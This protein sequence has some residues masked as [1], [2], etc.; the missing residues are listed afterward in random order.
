MTPHQK[1]LKAAKRG[2]GLRLTAAEVA[3]LAADNA[4]ATCAENDDVIAPGNQQ[5][6]IRCGQ[7]AVFINPDTG[8]TASYHAGC[9]DCDKDG[10][11]CEKCYRSNEYCENC[12]SELAVY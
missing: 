2:T 9:V 8:K 10:C 7:P 12:G 3:R 5:A 11:V 4:I 6:C 1:I